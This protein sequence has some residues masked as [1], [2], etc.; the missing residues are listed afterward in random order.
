MI[1]PIVLTTTLAPLPVAACVRIPHPKKVSTSQPHSLVMRDHFIFDL[2]EWSLFLADMILTFVMSACDI[3]I[4]RKK[5]GQT[6]GNSIADSS[7]L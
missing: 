5:S 6:F 2:D 1:F 7:Y 4:S 3:K